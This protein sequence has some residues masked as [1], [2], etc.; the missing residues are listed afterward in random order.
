MVDLKNATWVI[1]PMMESRLF[2]L[3]HQVKQQDAYVIT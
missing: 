2:V 1:T 3:E